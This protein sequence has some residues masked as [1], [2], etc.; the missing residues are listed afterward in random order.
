[1]SERFEPELGH[2]IFGQ[3]HKEFAVPKIWEAALAA[4]RD[5][6]A[7]VRWN[8][9]QKEGDCPFGDT[10]ARFE[11]AAFTVEAYSWDDEQEQPWNFKWREVEISWYKYLGRGMS[12]NQR[13]SA[14]NAA[15]MLEDC[16]KAVHEYEASHDR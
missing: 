6:L 14:D 13:L 12:A 1:M 7:R 4:L 8:H 9:T 2:A 3:P 15:L 10:G 16:I 5:E 11:C